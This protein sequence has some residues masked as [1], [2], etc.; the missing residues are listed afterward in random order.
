MYVTNTGEGSESFGSC[1]TVWSGPTGSTVAGCVVRSVP[2][3][4]T[5]PT[6]STRP[7]T[8]HSTRNRGRLSVLDLLS[9]SDTPGTLTP[10]DTDT[11]TPAQTG[12]HK[13]CRG[14][15]T[16]GVEVG[17]TQK[18]QEGLDVLSDPGLTHDNRM[19]PGTPEQRHDSISP[20]IVC[21]VGSVGFQHVWGRLGGPGDPPDP[22][23]L[24]NS[25]LRTSTVDGKRMGRG[26]GDGRRDTVPL[27]EEMFTISRLGVSHG[28][29][30]MST[31]PGNRTVD[32]ESPDSCSF[33]DDFE[34]VVPVYYTETGLHRVVRS[35]SSGPTS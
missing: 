16:P 35:R 29:T 25:E 33:R 8:L 15:G 28:R 21:T 26:T 27:K 11:R 31:R 14:S 5:G 22:V 2:G 7:S 13:R 24:R 34:E 32:V 17:W 1:S 30:S 4:G 9:G 10:G 19:S 3:P 23:R 18:V 12:L 20:R 6:P